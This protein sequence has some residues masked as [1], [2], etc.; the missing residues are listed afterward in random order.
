M[1][2]KNSPNADEIVGYLENT[3]GVVPPKRLDVMVT[4]LEALGLRSLAK[5]SPKSLPFLHPL[6]V[7]IAEKGRESAVC[8]AVG[9]DKEGIIGLLRWPKASLKADMPVVFCDAETG[10]VTL[11][12]TKV[13]DY[14]KRLSCESDFFQLAAASC[15]I[16]ASNAEVRYE[17]QYEAGSVF[18]FGRGLDVYCVMRI[19]AFPSTY[20]ALVQSHK[21][22]SDVASA[23]I[24]CEKATS[25]F[26]EYGECHVFQAQVLAKEPGYE[27]EARDSARA[28]LAGPLWTMGVSKPT[29]DEMARLAGKD[30]IEQYASDL[31]NFK[32]GGAA[33]KTTST[34]EAALDQAAFSMDCLVLDAYSEGGE[35]PVAWA[36]LRPELAAL[37]TEGGLPEVANLVKGD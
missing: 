21:D 23:L 5:E 1:T 3:C 7:P 10:L 25:T 2:L 13:A 9:M 31:K 30:S 6:V 37:Y 8:P 36:D 29:M 16:D 26:G 20:R 15:I 34:L 14:V 33:A 28:A 32:S 4:S 19:A 11:L 18:N 35:L 27:L 22:K 12:A 24:T 17:D